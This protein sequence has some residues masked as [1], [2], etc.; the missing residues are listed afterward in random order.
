MPG[1]GIADAAA[2]LVGQSIGARERNMVRRFTRMTVWLGMAVMTLTGIFMYMAAPFMMGILSPDTQVCQLGVQVLRIEA[3]AEP[4]FAASIVASGA[5]RGAGDT[6]IP[7]IMNFISIWFVRLNH[8]CITFKNL[9]ITGGV[10]C[11]VCRALFPW[12]DFS[13]ADLPGKMDSYISKA[14]IRII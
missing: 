11:H 8:F 3:F 9:W 10:V 1:Y 7:S 2:T 5:L 13:G 6:F 12:N 4:L 14:D